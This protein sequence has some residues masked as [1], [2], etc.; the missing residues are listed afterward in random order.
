MLDVIDSGVDAAHVGL[1]RELV[2]PDRRVGQV[3]DVRAFGNPFAAVV[4]QREVHSVGGGHEWFTA[5]SQ[6]RDH[7][8]HHSEHAELG[9]QQCVVRHVV[10]VVR[11][12]GMV[13]RQRLIGI[14]G[15]RL[16]ADRLPGLQIDRVPE[17]G[18]HDLAGGQGDVTAGTELSN[19]RGQSIGIVG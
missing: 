8:V 18:S 1:R 3:D 16:I 7:V 10:E 13:D 2:I 14:F 17:D 9:E 12:G 6:W 19:L 5:A 15:D 11:A 4:S